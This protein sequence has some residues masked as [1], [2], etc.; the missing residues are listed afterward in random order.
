[1]GAAFS[2]HSKANEAPEDRAA[3]TWANRKP[4][5][6]ICG[7]CHGSLDDFEGEDKDEDEDEEKSWG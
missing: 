3:A 6:G 4:V 2:V 5:E 1:M 7:V